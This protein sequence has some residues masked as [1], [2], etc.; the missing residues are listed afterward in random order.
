[1]LEI[2]EIK[3]IVNSPAMTVENPKGLIFRI[4]I[5]LTLL[6]C[7]RGGDAKRLKASWLKE[8]DD[9]G[10]LL[11]LSKKKNYAGRFKDLYAESGSSLIPLDISENIYIPKLEKGS[12]NTMMH[13]I[14]KDAK[15]NFKDYNVSLLIAIEE[16]E[17]NSHIALKESTSNYINKGFS[18]ASDLLF[19]KFNKIDF[20]ANVNNEPKNKVD[21]KS[22]AKTNNEIN[23]DVRYKK[24]KISNI[25]IENC[26]NINI[27]ISLM[28]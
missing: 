28:P 5:W 27:N 25:T 19:N 12:H 8:L 9:G 21:N 17:P 15:L 14:C 26:S 24:A 18:K 16:A 3:F 1:S 11:E 4:W 20:E 6:C 22:E 2:D 23:S 13:N 7:L 10:M